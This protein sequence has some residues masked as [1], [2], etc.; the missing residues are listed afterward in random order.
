VR[1]VIDE[2]DDSL[3]DDMM[4]EVKRGRMSDNSMGL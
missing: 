1:G 2:M 3:V 4:R